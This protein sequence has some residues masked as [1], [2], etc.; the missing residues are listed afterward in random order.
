MTEFKKGDVVF[1]SKDHSIYGSIRE[2]DS[3]DFGDTVLVDWEDGTVGYHR[4]SRII[5]VGDRNERTP[6]Y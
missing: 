2:V 1:H 3:S 4:S 5:L 6:T